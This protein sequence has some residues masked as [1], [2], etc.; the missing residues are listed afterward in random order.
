MFFACGN[1]WG[2]MGAALR[3]CQVKCRKWP[4]GYVDQA[5]NGEGSHVG[6][7]GWSGDSNF[8]FVEIMGFVGS[9]YLDGWDFSSQWLVGLNLSLGSTNDTQSGQYP[10]PNFS[11]FFSVLAPHSL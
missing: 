3:S 10:C 9:I 4:N 5:F 2:H 11:F 8:G 1:M 7:L 6:R